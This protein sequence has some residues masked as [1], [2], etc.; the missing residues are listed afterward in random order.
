MNILNKPEMDKIITLS[1]GLR[2]AN[3]S[4]PHPFTFTDGSILPAVSDELAN[5]MMLKTIED[6]LDE[7]G[8]TISIIF[9]MTKEITDHLFEWKK[10]WDKEYV[11]IILIPLPIMLILKDNWSIDKIKHSPFRTVR[12]AD[13]ITKTVHI[14]KFC[15]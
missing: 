7:S 1:N 5:K 9:E 14:N 6:E 15:I 3:F 8:Q 11:N 13:R 12:I 10:L 2:V 4:S